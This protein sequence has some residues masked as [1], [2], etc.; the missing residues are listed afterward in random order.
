ML[1]FGMADEDAHLPTPIRSWLVKRLFRAT[2][3][4][5]G[6]CGLAASA[7]AELVCSWLSACEKHVLL[8]LADCQGQRMA[9]AELTPWITK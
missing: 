3:L 6:D 5:S 9:M 7:A 8:H 1:I 2:A 4:G